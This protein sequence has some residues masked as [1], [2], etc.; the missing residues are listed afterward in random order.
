[1]GNYTLRFLD[2]KR[3]ITSG[4]PKYA[5]VVDASELW[6]KALN[7]KPQTTPVDCTRI[8][9]GVLGMCGPWLEYCRR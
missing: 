2:P 7:P 6:A 9:Q 3:D 8:L 4:L 1:M 5:A